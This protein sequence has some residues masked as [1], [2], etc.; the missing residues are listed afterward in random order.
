MAVLIGIEEGEVEGLSPV[1]AERIGINKATKCWSMK[2]QDI[3]GNYSSTIDLF[4]DILLISFKS[5]LLQYF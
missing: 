3:S 2:D 4:P 1:M 5:K